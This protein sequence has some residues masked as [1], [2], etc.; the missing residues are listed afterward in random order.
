MLFD[1][2]KEKKK[3][4]GTNISKF[5][6]IESE[7]VYLDSSN[8]YLS[9]KLKEFDRSKSIHFTSNGRFSLDDMIIYFA[10]NMN[11]PDCLI[12]S[13]NIS[14]EAA[15]NLLNAKNKHYINS[16]RLLLNGRK[17]Q[18]FKDAV[19]ILKHFAKIKF[20]AIHAKV[21]LIY[22]NKEFVTII[23]SGNL[24]SNNNI[25]RGCIFFDKERW[26]NYE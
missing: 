19:D 12:S 26:H 22:T 6:E 25:E 16:L 21:A 5:S 15:R 10:R 1:I 2:N 4:K 20:I 17:Q 13:F 9:K 24:S 14:K 11:N 8:K 7:N 3:K 23:T 18:Q